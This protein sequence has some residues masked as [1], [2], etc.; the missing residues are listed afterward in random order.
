MVTNICGVACNDGGDGDQVISKVVPVSRA[1]YTLN[2][3]DIKG[4]INTFN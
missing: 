3:L 1:N 4:K 2:L